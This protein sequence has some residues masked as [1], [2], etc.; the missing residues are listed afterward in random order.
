MAGMLP[1]ALR[2]QQRGCCGGACPSP[3]SAPGL[4]EAGGGGPGAAWSPG[5]EGEAGGGAAR[6][7]PSLLL[8][9]EPVKLHSHFPQELPFHLPAPGACK[10][11]SVCLQR[12]SSPCPPSLSVPLQLRAPGRGAQRQPRRTEAGGW[13][14]GGLSGH[15]WEPYSPRQLLKAAGRWGMHGNWGRETAPETA[16]VEPR[17]PCPGS[18]SP[19]ALWTRRGQPPE[20][21]RFPG[22]GEIPADLRSL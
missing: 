9:L 15:P 2:R 7:G 13:G 11:A 4:G 6:D 1:T 10:T 17:R 16:P 22:T 20:S 5:A 8:P 19:G 3:P 18:P 21:R 12:L 14:R